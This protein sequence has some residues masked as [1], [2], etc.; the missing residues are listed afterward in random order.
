M[1]PLSHSLQ[2]CLAVYFGYG[3]EKQPPVMMINGGDLEQVGQLIIDC[4]RGLVNVLQ[5]QSPVSGPPLPE[6]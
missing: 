4:L 1:K 5:Y 2:R 3:P 6:L